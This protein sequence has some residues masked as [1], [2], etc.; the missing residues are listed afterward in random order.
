MSEKDQ[1]VMPEQGRHTTKSGAKIDFDLS[2]GDIGY[3]DVNSILQARNPYSVVAL[4][5]EHGSLTGAEESLEIEINS[6]GGTHRGHM[7]RFSQVSGNR[8]GVGRA[9]LN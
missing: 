7:A 9:E 5:K 3:V 6:A 1:R 4:L 8:K 2:D